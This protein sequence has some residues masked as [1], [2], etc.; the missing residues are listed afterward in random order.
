MRIFKKILKV[1]GICLLVIILA[2]N[3]SIIL[4]AKSNPD[5]VPSIFGYKPFIVLS[6]SM[7][8]EIQ[9]GDLVLVK[10]VDVSSLKEQDIIAFRDK[11]GTVTTHRIIKVID[12]KDGLNSFITKG[13]ANN[14]E[15][16]EVNGSQVEGL[17]QKRFP[18][19]G[20]AVMFIQKPV[21]F[22]VVVLSIFIV[23]LLVFMFQNRKINKE[24]QFENEEERKAF[25]EFKK[26]R[27]K[28][29]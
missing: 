21:G 25:E 19:L 27:E 2:I 18:K 5:K 14:V 23:C 28:S 20:N 6:G 9:V 29:K 22:A 26:S 3:I 13:D 17:Y 11:E 8:S 4:Q 15:D 12:N 7:E 1:L 24:I 10:E 16:G